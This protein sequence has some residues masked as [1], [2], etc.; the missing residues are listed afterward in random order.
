MRRAGRDA[1]NVWR[2]WQNSDGCLGEGDR[3]RSRMTF[4]LCAPFRICAVN[5]QMYFCVVAKG[6]C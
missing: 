1:L 2:E 6:N 5:V 3:G 4:T